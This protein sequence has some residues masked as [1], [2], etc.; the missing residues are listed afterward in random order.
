MLYMD[1]CFIS[2]KPILEQWA[3]AARTY[4][5]D[6]LDRVCNYGENG[7]IF[8]K[9]AFKRMS[10]RT[11]ILDISA[12][13]RIVELIKS[14]EPN[15]HLDGLAA[16]GDLQISREA[17]QDFCRVTGTRLPDAA[18]GNDHRSK[19]LEAWEV[20]PP[21]RAPTPTELEHAER[22]R[23]ERQK[24][25]R[26]WERQHRIKV[27]PVRGSRPRPVPPPTVNGRRPEVEAIGA[28]S[29]AFG[30]KESDLQDQQTRGAPPKPVARGDVHVWYRARVKN[31]LP[32]VRP[33]SGKD[34]IHDA[35]QAFPD[36]TVSR[37]WLRDCRRQYAPGS[38]KTP[39]P[40]RSRAKVPAARMRD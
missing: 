30:A 22:L 26:A 13:R 21:K 32:H 15:F 37:D 33:P 36:C 17:V 11:A 6:I 10:D 5:L 18:L 20:A 12:V 7:L 31:W 29:A 40:K 24:T 3:L 8:N 34:D 39:G 4:D 9:L 14:R 19:W 1:S 27:L 25:S 28:Q 2:A 38:W 23:Q 35:K 16:Y